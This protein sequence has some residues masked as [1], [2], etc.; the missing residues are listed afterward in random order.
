MSFFESSSHGMN[1]S[2][3]LLYLMLPAYLAN[4]APPF[5]KYWRGWNRPIHAYWLGAHKTVVSFALGVAAR[6]VTAFLQSRVASA[7]G[8]FPYDD[9]FQFGLAMSVAA[10]TGDAVK[11]FGK[12]R[13]GI[14]PGQSWIPADQLDFVVAGLAVLSLWIPLTWMDVVWILI[15]SFTGDVLINHAS[16]HLGIRETKW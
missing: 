13:L 2:V 16:F 15:V 1:R 8:L 5:V 4:M 3:E 7:S 12:R 6:V 11:S 9:W 10:M 14:A